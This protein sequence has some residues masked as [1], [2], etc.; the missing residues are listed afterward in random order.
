MIRSLSIL[1]PV[2]NIDASLLVNELHQQL[3]ACDDVVGNWEI[4]LADDGSTETATQQANRD[5]AAL[6]HGVR[7]IERG[8]NSGRAVI[9]NFLAEQARFEWLLFIDSDLRMASD[10]FIRDYLEQADQWLVV[11]GGIT[12]VRDESAPSDCLRYRYELSAQQHNSAAQRQQQPYHNFHTANFMVR[13]DV[14]LSLPFDSR[15]RHYGYEDVLFGRS[16]SEHAIPILHIDNPVAFCVFDSN[17]GYVCK[18][19]EGLRTLR[20]FAAELQG[21]VS[22]LTVVRRIA[23][24]RLTWAVRLWHRLFGA[25]ERRRLI[26]DDHAALTLLNIYK[27]GYYVSLN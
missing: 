4:L 20:T 15:F 3:C 14:M 26:S 25:A 18:V 22:L 27:L 6:F 16:L 8:F 5:C 10:R 19:E 2:Y 21:Y 24:L 1:L 7:Y 9:R 23:Q 12:I 17:E 11:D 13:R